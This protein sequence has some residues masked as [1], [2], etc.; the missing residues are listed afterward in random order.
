M[1]V[2]RRSSERGRDGSRRRSFVEEGP[3]PPG[4]EEAMRDRAGR[5]G[6]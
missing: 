4:Y 2:D 3:P 6:R 5:G 1:G